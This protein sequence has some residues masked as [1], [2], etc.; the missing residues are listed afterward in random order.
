MNKFTAGLLFTC[1]CLLAQTSQAAPFS[2]RTNASVTACPDKAVS[3]PHTDSIFSQSITG[4]GWFLVH[5]GSPSSCSIEGFPDS[6]L[7]VFGFANATADLASGQLR[8]LAFASGGGALASAPFV[9]SVADS[10]VSDTI[11]IH[12][13]FNSNALDVLVTFEALLNGFATGHSSAFLSMFAVGTDVSLCV[14]GYELDGCSLNS[15][16][17]VLND[18]F[19]VRLETP[20]VFDA[21]LRTVADN[22]GFADASHTATLCLLLPNGYTYTSASGVFLARAPSNGCSLSTVP[23]PPSYALILLGLVALF[24]FIP[25][26]RKNGARL[27]R[28]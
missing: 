18:S 4:D 2:T 21:R 9:E 8:A 26:S 1:I 15:I 25:Q 23:E 12:N 22:D 28:S 5:D 7:S 14:A 13:T 16:S 24:R 20:F 17:A 6:G 10:E 27:S 3:D 11:T 19:L